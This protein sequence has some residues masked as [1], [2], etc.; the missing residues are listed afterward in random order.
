MPAVQALDRAWP[1]RFVIQP[2]HMPSEERE[3]ETAKE[4]V[5]TKART[6]ARAKAK[7]RTRARKAKERVRH[8]RAI[9][10]SSK[11]AATLRV[12]QTQTDP[13]I[14]QGKDKGKDRRK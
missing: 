11:V 5:R 14:L 1:D 13:R 2:F 10:V 6:K 12:P 3:R 8:A 7:E 9:S 4:R